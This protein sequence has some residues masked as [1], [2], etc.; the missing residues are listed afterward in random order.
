MGSSLFCLGQNK[1]NQHK[2]S[3]SVLGLNIL[4]ENMNQNAIVYL[5]MI[6]SHLNVIH[7]LNSAW[8]IVF[9]IV[10]L[11]T[12]EISNCIKMMRVGLSCPGQVLLPINFQS[13]GRYSTEVA[14]T[15]LAQQFRV[16]I[17]KIFKMSFRA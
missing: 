12:L 1:S 13:G 11:L 10:W 16:R 15:P 3:K 4:S 5:A 6:I 17:P 14:L 9:K 8:S 2:K 7:I